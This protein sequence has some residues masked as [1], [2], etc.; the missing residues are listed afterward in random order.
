MLGAAVAGAADYMDTDDDARVVATV[1][2]T[3]MVV[4][5]I[6][7]VVSLVLRLGASTGDRTM[8]SSVD[9]RL[10][11]WRLGS[12]VGGENVYGFGN[13]VNR[14]AWRFG[15]AKWTK[16]DITEI[17]ENTPTAAKAGA[18]TLVVVRQGDRLRDALGLCAR[19]RPFG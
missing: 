1:H 13:M 10:P 18:Q 17:P 4:A 11:D 19:R 15:E 12:W 16:L 3:L 5:L 7:Y 14:H 9:R 2:S 8:P 6:V